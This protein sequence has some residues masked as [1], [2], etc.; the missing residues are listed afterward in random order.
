MFI[1]TISSP[2]EGFPKYFQ[3]ISNVN[4]FIVQ[5]EG[6]KID[7]QETSR[8]FYVDGQSDELIQRHP[9]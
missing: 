2:A 6:L 3:T 4:N 1:L 7:V 9:L 5:F 8:F